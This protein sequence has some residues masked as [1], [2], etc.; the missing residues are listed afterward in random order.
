M[1][2][3]T[4]DLRHGML[5]LDLDCGLATSSIFHREF[6]VQVWAADLWFSVA[7]KGQRIHVESRRQ[8]FPG[9]S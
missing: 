2:P 5:V 8:R 9:A 7:E 4:G 3:I 1:P 6:D